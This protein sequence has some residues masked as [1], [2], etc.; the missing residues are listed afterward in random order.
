MSRGERKAPDWTKPFFDRSRF[1]N[2]NNIRAVTLG[3]MFG[4]RVFMLPGPTLLKE[5]ACLY[6]VR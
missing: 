2:P 6:L 4:V 5:P 3:R 1:V